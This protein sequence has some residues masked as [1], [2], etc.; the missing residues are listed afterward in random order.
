MGGKTGGRSDGWKQQKRNQR[1][2]GGGCLDDRTEAGPGVE[3]T[4]CAP[5]AALISYKNFFFGGGGGV[6][7]KE[8]GLR[9]K[10]TSPAFLEAEKCV[11]AR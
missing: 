5:L 2:E 4:T 3:L 7:L 9:G 8:R 1:L 11:K 6:T 10:K